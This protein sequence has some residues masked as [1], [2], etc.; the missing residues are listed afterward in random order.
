MDK[1]STLRLVGVSVVMLVVG[2]ALGSSVF[3]MR[4]IET[5]TVLS[6]KIQ[7][8]TE[9]STVTQT[10]TLASPRSVV[11]I[12]REIAL[13]VVVLNNSALSILTKRILMQD[14]TI[15]TTSGNCTAETA[16]SG[17]ITSTQYLFN[18]HTITNSTTVQ[19]SSISTTTTENTNAT[20]TAVPSE[21]PIQ[22]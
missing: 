9:F 7:L 18:N 20:S 1:P 12:S 2:V 8:T 21:F 3:V 11:S 16:S 6:T 13:F 5:T 4:T 14:V 10:S 19:V 15:Y 17:L 22:C